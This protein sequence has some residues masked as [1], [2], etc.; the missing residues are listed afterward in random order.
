MAAILNSVSLKPQEDDGDFSD[1][2]WVCPSWPISAQT[3]DVIHQY[4]YIEPGLKRL[5]L[6][7]DF[8]VVFLS[9]GWM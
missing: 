5:A 2:I 8:E 3:N 7:V 1:I 4:W 6:T 9:S